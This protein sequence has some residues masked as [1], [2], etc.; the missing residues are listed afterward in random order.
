MLVNPGSSMLFLNGEGHPASTKGIS[1]VGTLPTSDAGNNISREELNKAFDREVHQ[2]IRDL[3]RHSPMGVQMNW[4]LPIARAATCYCLG[5]HG[6]GLIGAEAVGV[7]HVK[8]KISVCGHVRERTFS[9]NALRREM[10]L[11]KTG[12]P[13]WS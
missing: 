12:K 3:G 6:R 9:C 8:L 10:G 7:R 13:V 1:G 2:V 4:A 5:T 11:T